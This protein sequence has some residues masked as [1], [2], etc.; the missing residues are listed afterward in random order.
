MVCGAL[1]QKGM[2]APSNNSLPR[3]AYIGDIPVERTR[4]SA[5]LVH[6]LLEGYLAEKLLVVEGPPG[7][8]EIS[9]RLGGVRYVDAQDGRW[10]W[11]RT[12]IGGWVKSSFA[13]WPP[14]LAGRVW[15][16]VQEFGPEAVLAIAPF[17]MW[18]TAA[19]VARRLGVPLHLI[20]HDEWEQ[21]AFG[22]QPSGGWRSRAFDRVYAG[23]ASRLCVSPAM[24]AYYRGRTGAAGDVLMPTRS[25]AHQAFREPNAT[26]LSGGGRFTLGYAGSLW[27]GCYKELL[28]K[29]ALEASHLGM[30][31][32]IFSDCSEGD[33][34]AIAPGIRNLCCA[35][36][37]DSAVLPERLW[38]GAD[39]LL[40][41]SG[42]EEGYCLN[43]RLLFPSK[44][45]DYTAAGV[46]LLVWGPEDCAA[47]RWAREWDCAEVVTT[48]DPAAVGAALSGLRLDPGRREALVRRAIVAGDACFGWDSGWRRF[49]AAL[50]RG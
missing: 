28:A 19:G 1:C 8:P 5:I 44:L 26:R 18:A 14:R 7:E 29:A 32:L 49:S 27:L 24:E 34:E 42:F 23:A 10:R 6:R 3:L 31:T 48:P 4:A 37:V 11:T 30:G 16:E 13:W 9:A 50:A 47:A 35:G 25:R 2:T 33:L 41:P 38:E 36:L 46:A 21:T 20:V 39:V 12:R 17:F 45:V 15:R 43:Q 22:G 40:V